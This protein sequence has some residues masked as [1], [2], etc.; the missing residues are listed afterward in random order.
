MPSIPS[1]RLRLAVALALA[2]LLAAA[3]APA[4]TRPPL[5]SPAL[6]A[7]ADDA[8]WEDDDA[9]DLDDLGLMLGGFSGPQA[10]TGVRQL[11][12]NEMGCAELYEETIALER[13]GSEQQ[14]RFDRAQAAIAQSQEQ[15]MKQSERAAASVGMGVVGGGLLSMVPGGSLVANAAM[16]AA[17]SSRA[18][19]V[20]DSTQKMVEGT[21][22][23]SEV[24][25][26]LEYANARR[27]HLT[28]L[29]LDKGCKLSDV[30]AASGGPAAS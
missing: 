4:P 12:D 24:G 16:S 15:M 19:A 21:R 22:E 5:D 30:Q 28:S 2:T 1:A 14:A 17:T 8:D 20:R 11:G 25:R 13:Q 7:E 18:A 10:V 27:D 23:L 29:F 26:D 3:C 9:G 6:A